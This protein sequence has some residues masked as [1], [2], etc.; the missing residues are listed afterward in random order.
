MTGC[1]CT[2]RSSRSAPAESPAVTRAATLSA[3]AGPAFHERAAASAGSSPFRYASEVSGRVGIGRDELAPVELVRRLVEHRGDHHGQVAVGQL[4]R[5]VV[6]VLARPLSGGLADKGGLGPRLEQVGELL[7][8]GEGAPADD[9]EQ[10]VGPVEPGAPEDLLHRVAVER[11][12]AA[13]VVADVE[14]HARR[15]QRVGEGKDLVPLACDC[16]AELGS[17]TT[18]RSDT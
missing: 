5:S 15:L 11:A 17:G 4:Q 14:D 7:P 2:E 8:G 18:P 12:V 6:T 1:C 3:T 10:P 16:V 9:D 13:H